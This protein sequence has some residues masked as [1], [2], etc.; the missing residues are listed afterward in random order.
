MPR[1][2]QIERWTRWS[3]QAALG[4]L[5]LYGLSSIPDLNTRWGITVASIGAVAGWIAL[6][7]TG[8]DI[9]RERPGIGPLAALATT[10][11][12]V[13]SV[14]ALLAVGR[15]S[16]GDPNAYLNLAKGLLAGHGLVIHDPFFGSAW[17]ALF[18]PLYPLL[19]A[20][21]GA[22]FGFDTA[23]VLTL[24]TLTDGATAWLL[25][26]LGSR[27]GSAVAGRRA[28]WLYL[29]WP[30]VLFS[31]P[32]AQKESLCALL[33][34]LLALAW[35]DRRAGWRGALALGVPAGLLALTQPGEAPLA[36]VFGLVLVG[37]IG[38]WP[39]LRT[40]L[41]GG[42]VAAVVLVPWW[43]R[44]WAVFHA[45]VPL[46]TA[47]GASLW[48]GNNPDATGNWQPPPP[49]LKGIPELAYG[50]RIGAIAV[51]WIRTHPVGFVRLTLTKF[52]RA[53]GIAQFGVT[54]LVAMGPP[55]PR[56]LAAALWP[57][58]MLAHLALLGGAAFKLGPRLPFTLVLLIA[59]CGLQLLL[60][61]VWFEFG[62]RH[63]EFVTPFLLLALCWSFAAPAVE[64]AP[65][66]P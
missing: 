38:L 66:T 13:R 46:T 34:L 9:L 51:E 37:R 32:L 10:L 36:A 26:V 11:V 21:W 15:T 5:L 16:T 41:Q 61:G 31:A 64:K 42:V 55:V 27:L 2:T 62:E 63:R 45:F 57:L 28:A 8:F 56:V 49:A 47:S 1:R 40:G 54:R 3:V 7:A 30:S 59:A 39:M 35:I 24:G 44:N 58:S 17:R 33:V 6:A 52:V 23:A 22:V 18:P 4:L 29:I 14:F 50:K 25:F 12:V 48:I 43:V 20:G 65:A 19:L 60:F 53:S